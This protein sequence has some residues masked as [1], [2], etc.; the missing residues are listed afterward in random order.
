M[1]A[2]ILGLL[3]AILLSLLIR[4]LGVEIGVWHKPI[5]QW[6]VRVAAGRLPADE[7]AAAESEW[8][9]V[10]G[11]MRSPTAQLLHSLSFTLS[12]LRIR[13]EM[14]P[15]AQTTSLFKTLIAI[16]VGGMGAITG[17]M[18]AFLFDHKDA[19]VGI[20]Q[21]HVTISKPVALVVL[22]ALGLVS[23]V[24]AYVNHRFM[25]WYFSRRARR[26]ASTPIE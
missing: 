14:E 7:C 11:D 15:Q 24:M 23:G 5:C 1:G 20:V 10:I 9:A 8:L 3:G 13:Q 12:A 18:S 26:R 19:V 22:F 16:Q 17:G 21:Q 2:M 25:M 4:W 6:L